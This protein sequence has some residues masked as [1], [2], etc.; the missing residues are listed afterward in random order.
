MPPGQ[1]GLS[2]FARPNS[3]I[4]ISVVAFIHLLYPFCLA[5]NAR[6]SVIVVQGEESFSALAGGLQNALHDPGGA[7][8]ERGIDSLSAAWTTEPARKDLTQ[9]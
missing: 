9:I 8:H 6:R 7:P 3:S 4:T 5:F 1:Q 2:D